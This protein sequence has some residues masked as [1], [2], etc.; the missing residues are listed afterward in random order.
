MAPTPAGLLVLA[1]LGV[2]MANFTTL[3]GGSSRT[4]LV[5]IGSVFVALLAGVILDQVQQ[6]LGRASEGRKP[7]V[8]ELFIEEEINQ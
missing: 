3:V 1:G 8:D 2:A 4:A 7:K 5:L 6:R